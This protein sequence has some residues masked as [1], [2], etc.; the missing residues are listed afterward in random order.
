LSSGRSEA[1]TGDDR[2]GALQH[3]RLRN[4][5]SPAPRPRGAFEI[6][7][8]RKIF[9][10]TPRIAAAP[11]AS[12]PRQLSV[13]PAAERGHATAGIYVAG[14]VALT[15]SAVPPPRPEGIVAGCTARVQGAHRCSE[16]AVVKLLT[17]NAS[18]N[19]VQSPFRPSSRGLTCAARNRV[20]F[21]RGDAGW[22]IGRG[23]GDPRTRPAI[24]RERVP[25]CAW[26]SSRGVVP[27][28]A[29]PLMRFADPL[30]DS[31]AR[32]SRSQ[33]SASVAARARSDRRFGIE[34]PVSMLKIRIPGPP[35]DQSVTP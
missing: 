31:A 19:V 11:G 23:A 18:A 24:A 20:P 22:R 30:L 29:N 10:G 1:T 5:S 9:H 32:G 26:R 3:E 28:V 13:E 4:P 35:P 7:E 27:D 6:E 16:S 25:L 21:P 17:A 33:R 34:S 2:A 14:A 8:N 12:G 15:R